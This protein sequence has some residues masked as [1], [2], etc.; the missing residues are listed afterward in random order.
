[1]DPPGTL[2]QRTLSLLL[3][4]SGVSRNVSESDLAALEDYLGFLCAQNAPGLDHHPYFAGGTL[5]SASLAA[6][7]YLSLLDDFPDAL[8]E[9]ILNAMLNSNN[10]LVSFSEF[11]AVRSLLEDG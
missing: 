4:G 10:T 6:G 9:A 8:P 3:N 1:M 7:H 11:E 2:G 5:V